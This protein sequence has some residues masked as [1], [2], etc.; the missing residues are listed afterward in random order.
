MF[1]SMFVNKHV[2]LDERLRVTAVVDPAVCP[3]CFIHLSFRCV[4]AGHDAR[5][6]KRNH[7]RASDES[8]LL[9]NKILGGAK[10]TPHRTVT[11][12]LRRSERRG[13]NRR[14]S[15]EHRRCARQRLCKGKKRARER[16]DR[17]S[18]SEVRT[19]EGHSERIQLIFA[20]ILKA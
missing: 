15:V 7:P 13:R 5:F 12:P 2:I 20:R 3:R 6:Q 4:D 16:D 9:A 1:G 19:H 14:E 8:S 18:G 10:T 11:S 17:L